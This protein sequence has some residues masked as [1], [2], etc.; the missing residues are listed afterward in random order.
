MLQ[1]PGHFPQAAQAR[2]ISCRASLTMAGLIGCT[3]GVSDF[4]KRRCR[5]RQRS[6]ALLVP[7]SDPRYAASPNLRKASKDVSASL[8]SSIGR[9]V[10]QRPLSDTAPNKLGSATSGGELSHIFNREWET[11]ARNASVGGL[12]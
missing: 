8:V 7:F 3:A 1:A 4:S 2:F 6:V 11:N 9:S 10:V 5:D 12:G